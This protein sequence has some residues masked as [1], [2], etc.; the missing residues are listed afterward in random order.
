MRHF[1]TESGKSKGQFYT[2]AEVSRVIAQV[3]DLRYAL[4]SNQSIYDPTCGSGPLLLKAHDEAKHRA[5]LEPRAVRAGNGQRHVRP[6]PLNMVLHDCPEAE[7]WTRQQ[8]R[9]MSKTPT[10]G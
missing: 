7:I 4:N 8:P 2:P 1:P 3:L 9:R 5:G 6:G 10:A